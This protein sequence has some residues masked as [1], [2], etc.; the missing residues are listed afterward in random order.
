MSETGRA[1]P[2]NTPNLVQQVESNTY[3]VLPFGLDKSVNMRELDP[4][5]ENSRQNNKMTNVD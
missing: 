1:A 3:K 5:G 4:A 2:D